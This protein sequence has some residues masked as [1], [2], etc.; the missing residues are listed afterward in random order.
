MS[1]RFRSPMRAPGPAGSA[2]EVYEGPSA[3]AGID[4][5][6]LHRLEYDSKSLPGTILPFRA[7]RATDGREQEEGIATGV[8]PNEPRV[9]LVSVP[10]NGEEEYDE[11]P[12]LQTTEAVDEPEPEMIE[13]VDSGARLP[14][15]I[16]V[17]RAGK[18]AIELGRVAEDLTPEPEI[19]K[20]D[21]PTEVVEV[22]LAEDPDVIIFGIEEVTGAGL[23][24]LAQVHRAQP[25]IVIVLSDNRRKTWSAAQMAASGAS[26]FLPVNPS[27]GRLRT[28]LA[29]ALATS[30]QL[31][32]ESI[33]VTERVVVQGRAPFEPPAA[34]VPAAHAPLARVFTV[35]SASGGSGKTMVATNLAAYL[36]KATGGRVLLIDLDLQ[37]GE[38]APSLHLHPQ[39]TIEDLL[40]DP[41]EL[42]ETVVEHTAGFRALC[43]PTDV[44]AAEKIGPSEVGDILH[45]ARLKF[46]YIVVDTPPSL[47]EICLAVFD[48]SEKII[49][50]ANMDVPSLKNL[51]RYLETIETLDVAPDKAVPL[52]NRSD[53]GIGLDIQGVGQLFPQGFLAVLPASREIPW[54]TNMGVPIL[55][56]KPKSEIS[57]QLAGGFMKLVPPVAGAELP[58]I[59]TSQTVR[60]S[61]LLGRKRGLN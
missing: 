8:S 49:V 15:V 19:L 23:K 52:I 11:E 33:V 5:A 55:E 31:R 50:T 58:W 43:A 56:A 29:A 10:W 47:N 21:R 24:R 53:T 54:A 51:R 34:K 4:Y 44:L 59:A 27:R 17:D 26:D 32:T 40:S 9:T 18:L 35:A 57:R 39:R 1:L 45:V 48:Q 61:G 37:F 12:E 14:K 41:E 7:A 46:D 22:A 6:L 36:V 25:K 16:V 60:R 30:E 42:L 2:G 28:K 38:I 20:L 3:A 13:E